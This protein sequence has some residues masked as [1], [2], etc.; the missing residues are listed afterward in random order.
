L[1]ASQSFASWS[2]HGHF[3]HRGLMRRVLSCLV[4]LCLLCL[5]LSPSLSPFL[6]PTLGTFLCQ[7]SFSHSTHRPVQYRKFE[8][9]KFYCHLFCLILSLRQPLPPPPHPTNTTNRSP[10][11]GTV[12]KTLEQDAD[13][14][15][16]SVLLPINERMMGPLPQSEIIT[17]RPMVC[18]RVYVV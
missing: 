10:A 4:S 11:S 17:S 1:H 13:E 2:V 14:C 7:P 18:V 12:V 8:K 9:S 15:Y 3:F 16:Q 5:T 6:S